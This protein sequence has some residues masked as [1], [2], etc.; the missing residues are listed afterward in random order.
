MNEKFKAIRGSE[1]RAEDVI[2]WLVDHGASNAAKQVDGDDS[3]VLYFVTEEG[4][5][6]CI[7]TEYKCL[8]DVEEL[9][10]WRANYGKTYHFICDSGVILNKHDKKDDIDDERYEIGNYFKTE[11]KAQE[12]CSKIVKILKE[13]V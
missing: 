6:G 7:E 3:D 1:E 13:I 11:S 5:A 2:K 12:M 8:V 9:P 4:N 10:R